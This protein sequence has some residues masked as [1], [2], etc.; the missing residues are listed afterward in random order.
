MLSQKYLR[1][2]EH[3]VSW[4]GENDHGVALS[5]GVYYIVLHT[6]THQLTKKMVYL[7]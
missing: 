5:S 4:S 2:G 3:H 7:R 6:K 1:G